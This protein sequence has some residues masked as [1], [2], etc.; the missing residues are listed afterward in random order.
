MI[1]KDD[2][3]NEYVFLSKD[4]KYPDIAVSYHQVNNNIFGWYSGLNKDNKITDSYF[5]LELDDQYLNAIKI[6]ASK[7]IEEWEINILNQEHLTEYK[8]TKPQ[9]KI[10]KDCEEDFREEWFDK[11]GN[12]KKIRVPKMF[13][14]E[15]ND[16]M[17]IPENL[18]VPLLNLLSQFWDLDRR[19]EISLVEN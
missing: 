7:N 1:H 14:T 4:K 2:F 10:L 12:I 3:K 17:F 15:N 16:K 9:L 11:E 18:N 5:W 6:L 19:I 8:I 13:S